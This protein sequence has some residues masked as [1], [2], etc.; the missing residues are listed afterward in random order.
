MPTKKCTKC[1]IEKETSAFS[2]RC[3]IK[4]KL[5]SHCKDCVK[6]KSREYQ[7][8]STDSN[9]HSRFKAKLLYRYGITLLQYKQ[10]QE[11]QNN[12]C[13]ICKKEETNI[14]NSSGKITRLAVDHCHTSGKIRGLLCKNCN[15]LIGYAK[16]NSEIL[17]NASSYIE[18]QQKG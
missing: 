5:R 10:L 18:E 16:E 12:K 7:E 15:L 13:A 2:F 8:K 4:D 11:K 3:D 6:K 17:L 1:K 9:R 14:H